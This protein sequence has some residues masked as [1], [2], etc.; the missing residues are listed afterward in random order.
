MVER[1]GLY[2]DPLLEVEGDPYAG[3]VNPYTGVNPAAQSGLDALRSG[4]VDQAVALDQPVER[5]RFQMAGGLSTPPSEFGMAELEAFQRSTTPLEFAQ[6]F[7]APQQAQPTQGIRLGFDPDQGKYLINNTVVDTRDIQGL[8]RVPE[9]IQEPLSPE[10][11]AGNWRPIDIQTLK[12]NK[13]ELLSISFGERIGLGTREVLGSIPSGFGRLAEFAGAE[14][15]GEALVGLGEDIMPDEFDQARQAAVAEAE[16]VF[17]N[18][19]TG[20]LPQATPSVGVS[21]G[22]GIAGGLAGGALIG[23]PVGATIGAI[24]GGASAIFP[25]M[26][27]SAYDTALRQQGE[28]FVKSDRGKAEILGTAFATTGVQILPGTQVAGKVVPVLMQRAATQ[29]ANKATSGVAGTAAKV[30]FAEG[31]AE[32]AA[33]VIEQV[34]FDPETRAMMSEG[35]VAAMVPYVAETYGRE[36]ATAFAAGAVLGGGIGAITGAITQRAERQAPEPTSAEPTEGDNLLQPTDEAPSDTGQVVS[37]T[38]T[39]AETEAAAQYQYVPPDQGEQTNILL[40]PRPVA[41]EVVAEQEVVAPEAEAITPVPEAEPEVTVPP[42]NLRRGRAAATEVSA[43]EPVTAG[44]LVGRVDGSPFKTRVSAQ[45]QINNVARRRNVPASELEVVETDQGFFVTR[46]E[47]EVVAP[48]AAAVEPAVQEEVAI[49]PVVEPAPVTEEVAI[50]EGATRCHSRAKPSGGT[51][52][53]TSR[54]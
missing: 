13:D 37:P 46:V 52:T 36:A 18:F 10:L 15:V 43:L 40:R 14:G 30:G 20:V 5:S 3:T 48:Q 54:N 25:M 6:M 53:R 26:L 49:P 39:P 35:E 45:G 38:L 41:E 19:V 7:Q 34:A 8:Q 44:E 32:T 2:T 29:V 24:V 50:P 12:R 9:L 16:N 17:Q 28:D 42:V 22:S 11:P 4:L 23:G 47:E 1:V 21:V 31:M 33:L 27:N 51:C